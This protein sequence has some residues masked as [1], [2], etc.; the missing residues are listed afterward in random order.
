M[1]VCLERETNKD[2]LSP[3]FSFLSSNYLTWAVIVAVTSTAAKSSNV[4]LRT[5]RYL[6]LIT[7]PQRKAKKKK[8]MLSLD[9]YLLPLAS[10]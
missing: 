2:L 7:P 3:L 8:G 5:T 9:R 1:F 4:H 6:Y 10:P